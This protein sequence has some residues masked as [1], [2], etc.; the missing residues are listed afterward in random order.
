NSSPARRKLLGPK[1]NTLD[2]TTILS[3]RLRSGDDASCRNLYQPHQPRVL[4]VTPALVD[5]FND[6]TRGHFAWAGSAAK[7]AEEK[8]NPW[9]L[10]L[11]P[12]ADGEPVDVVVDKNTLM[13]SLQKTTGGIGTTLEFDYGEGPP[14][15]FRVAGLLSNSV[16]QG[17]LLIGEA[18]FKRL[19]PTISGYRSF[20][21]K[22]P[23]A[24]D[25]VATFLEDRFGDE[26]FDTVDAR[27][28][29]AELMAV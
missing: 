24:P 8:A 10:L 29:R 23:S 6:S 28:K 1:S 20:L 18:D 11:T 12:A 22:A 26:G 7:M 15:R 25:K 5:Y 27:Q 17:S 9:R 16:L 19:F 2:G 21:I 14:V 13:Y 4:G 3:L